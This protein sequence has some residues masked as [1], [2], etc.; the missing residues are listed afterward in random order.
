MWNR[1]WKT[2]WHLAQAQDYQGIQGVARF[3]INRP[4]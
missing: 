3:L 2:W 1:L 4:L